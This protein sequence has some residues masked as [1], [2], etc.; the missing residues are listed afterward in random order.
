M[1]VLVTGGAGFIGSHL[2]EYLIRR[3]DEVTIIDNMITG[4]RRNIVSLVDHHSFTL[5]ESDIATI[6]LSD[7]PDYDVIFHLASP[8]S[9]VQYMRYA[10]ETLRT[11]AYGTDTVIKYLIAHP[12]CKMLLASTSEVYG[13]PLEHPQNEAYWGNV[14]PV[15]IRSCYDE[16]KRFAEALSYAAIRKHQLDIRIARIF[17]TYGPQMEVNDGRVVSNFVT[18]ALRNDAITV[19]G[20]GSQT[21]S[22][23][24]VSDMVEGLYRLGTKE[25]LAGEIINLGNPNEMTVMEIAKAVQ[26]ATTTASEITLTPIDA[27]DP[28]RRRPDSSKAEELLAWRPQVS[29]P[30]GLAQ[31]IAY[32]RSVI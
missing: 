31:T 6:D 28:K 18:Q 11:N 19:Y 20:D 5:I 21:R 2:S 27:D 4:N 17:N 7:H 8:A 25:S 32:F 10:L 26:E 30:E 15:G 14:N 29:F 1:K 22:L 13:D 3:G 12:R 24:Y 23:C 9:P 16:A